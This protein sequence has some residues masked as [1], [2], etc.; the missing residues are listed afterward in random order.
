VSPRWGLEILCIRVYKHFAPMAL[1]LHGI[2]EVESQENIQLRFEER[3]LKDHAEPVTAAELTPGRVY[4]SLQ[5]VDEAMFFPVLE[6]WMYLGKVLGD[7]SG[8]LIFQNFG[9]FQQGTRFE[10]AGHDDRHFFQI[11]TSNGLN[12]IFEYERALNVLMSC[13][14]KRRDSEV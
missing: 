2:S 12:H 7:D 1:N 8:K 9:S 13:A 5:F 10:T 14:L 11:T 4:F 3:E 6:P